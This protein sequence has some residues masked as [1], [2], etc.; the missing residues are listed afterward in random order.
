M[1]REKERVFDVNFKGAPDN[2]AVTFW[3]SAINRG[4][5]LVELAGVVVRGM[6]VPIVL[7]KEKPIETCSWY[8]VL[9]G[10]ISKNISSS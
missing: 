6:I 1:V 9:A 4:E 7:F 2:L 3:D 8:P 10:V 5:F